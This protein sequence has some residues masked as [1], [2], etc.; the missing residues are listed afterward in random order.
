[1]KTFKSF[2]MLAVLIVL[3]TSIPQAWAASTFYVAVGE[4]HTH[5]DNDCR[6][7]YSNVKYGSGDGEWQQIILTITDYT[8]NGKTVYQGTHTFNYGGYYNWQ[9]Y[10]KDGSGTNQKYREWYSGSW[11]SD[12][13]NGDVYVYDEEKWVSSPT[14]DAG[15]TIW[16]V[17][18]YDWGSTIKAHTWNGYCDYN[19]GGDYGEAMTSTGLQY[20]GHDIYRMTFSKRYSKIMFNCGNTGCRIGQDGDVACYANA[21]KMY[22]PGTGW[23]TPSFTSG[24]TFSNGATLIWDAGEIDGWTTT[25]MYYFDLVGDQD[26]ELTKI[27]ST[28]Q[29]YKTA[30]S[31]I[32]GGKWIMRKTNSW[33][34][35]NLDQTTDIT[36]NISGITIFTYDGTN[37]GEWKRNWQITSNAKKATGSKKIYFDNSDANWSNI[38]LKYGTQWFTRATSTATKV[39]GTANLY[40]INIPND[41]YYKE[42]FLCDATGSTGYNNIETMTSIGNRI[43]YQPYNYAADSTFIPTAGTGSS[44]KVW[45]TMTKM[46]GHT[47][48]VSI[49]APSHGT[50]TVAY[51]DESNTSQSKTS[52]S[53][54]VARTC[55]LTISS[56]ASTGYN[57][58]TL[59]INGSAHTSG[60]VHIIKQ[61]ITVAATFTPKSCSVTFDKE[62]GTEGSDGTTA[63]YDADM[64]TVSVPHKIGYKFDGY[65][66]GDNGTGNQYYKA[67]GTSYR[68]WNKDTQS[69]TTLY[70]KWEE[71]VNNFVGEGEGAESVK[72]NVAANWSRGFVPTN[73]YSEIHI[74]RG[75]NIGED[76]SYHVGKIIIDEGH[77]ITLING[78]VLEVAGTITRPDDEP[79]ETY[80][81]VL[82]SSG[83]KQSALILDNTAG[84]TKAS[85]SLYT[86]AHYDPSTS[87]Y[88]FQYVAV[89]MTIVNV[90]DAFSGQNVYTYVWNEGSGWER[91]GYYYSLFGFE[92]VGVTSKD[93]A[94]FHTTGTLVS[95]ADIV[96]R[97]LAYTS[98]D[99]AGMNMFGNSW[100]APVKISK[101]E[102][103]DGGDYAFYIYES[104][105]WQPYSIADAGDDVIPAMQAYL[106]TVTES[107]SYS[108]N[109]DDAVRGVK[110]ED[111][112]AAL[113]A[114]QRYASDV[115]KITLQV[116]DNERQS[117]LRLYEGEQ[118]SDGYDRGWE[119]KYIEG[120]GNSGQLY[121]QSNEK[122]VI[123]ATPNMEGTVVGFIPGVA[124]N[125]TISF[126]GDGKGYY[127]NDTELELSTLI[128]EGNTYEFTPNENTNAT[129][130]VI[131]KTP[132]RN[133][134][135]SIEDV[136]D[137]TKARKQ[138]IDGVLYIIRDGRIYNITG[139]LYK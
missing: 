106:I 73:D 63:T 13:H 124:D 16:F 57:P 59:T 20:N 74:K 61:N 46:A 22:V 32:K 99:G 117:N 21:G 62:G 5:W 54:A 34:G 44:P 35:A 1:M 41:A 70:A 135:T 95:T 125:Y 104:G 81:I 33:S 110:D 80:D 8:Y 115:A 96:D 127:L 126:E 26:I 17:N 71:D 10:I 69:N 111:R 65:W 84:N 91:R 136:N 98:G 118:F 47:H 9:F 66:D 6:T 11:K 76:E 68:T 133:T 23:I 79:T 134:P 86:T 89:P 60:N 52:G 30:T 42:Y 50:I 122:M 100:T 105:I 24:Y 97:P 113:R 112:T 88:S 75:V 94:T 83:S 93:G 53:F 51:K 49:T 29:F 82:S 27:G 87:G 18:G 25:H 101:I 3:I 58:T 55:S 92:A 114:P 36:E 2:K 116:T 130:F 121:A 56:A 123:M 85:V 38:Y 90:S 14:W 120:D 139:A 72:W 19:S 15:Y 31:T 40:Y 119:A 7:F 77:S 129:R 4:N 37:N 28:S 107:G 48:N 64:T 102:I 137:G 78:G 108:I 45:N 67:D 131:S 132:I 103:T 43:A 39:T 138:L 109:Y 12:L 128:A